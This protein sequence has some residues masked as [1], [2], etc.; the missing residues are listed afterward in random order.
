M[1]SLSL[2]LLILFIGSHSWADEKTVSEKQPAGEQPAGSEASLPAT[3]EEAHLQLE[4]LL[5]GEELAKIDAMQSEDEMI[6]YHL[7]LGM[8]IR[9]GWGL[10]SEGLLAQYMQKLGFHH[11]DD[12]SVLSWILSG[13]S[14]TKRIFD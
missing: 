4:K 9:N 5:P 7:T 10:W 2:F 8:D 6:E 3:L 1:K 13:A 14:G 11:P 12:M